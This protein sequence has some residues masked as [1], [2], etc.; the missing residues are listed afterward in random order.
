MNSDSLLASLIQLAE[1]S[2]R[3]L[4]AAPGQIA[5]QFNNFISDWQATSA[6]VPTA[7]KSS[8]GRTDEE[9]RKSVV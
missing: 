5:D 6:A 7:V 1:R 9:D 2:K 3:N 4:R 8:A